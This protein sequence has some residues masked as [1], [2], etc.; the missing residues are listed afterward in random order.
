MRTAGSDAAA[1]S[2]GV[3]RVTERPCVLSAA[4]LGI[5]FTGVIKVE[6]PFSTRAYPTIQRTE[7]RTVRF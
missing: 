1:A 7:I 5:F 6:F 4:S 2:C 3:E